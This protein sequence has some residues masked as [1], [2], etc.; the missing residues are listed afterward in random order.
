MEALKAI[1]II[2]LVMFSGTFFLVSAAAYSHRK[3]K[4]FAGGANILCGWW[5]LFPHGPD[6][7]EESAKNLVLWGRLSFLSILFMAGLM[8]WC[9]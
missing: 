7:I 2:A 3:D 1:S 8:A 6:G 4:S 5:L 9:N